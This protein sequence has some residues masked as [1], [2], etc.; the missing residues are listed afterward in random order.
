MILLSK[1][2]KLFIRSS[3]ESDTPIRLDGRNLMEERMIEIELSR[4]DHGSICE[5]N[6]GNTRVICVTKWDIV[7]PFHDRPN[8]GMLN[9]L[10]KLSHGTEIAHDN[11][12]NSGNSNSN[13]NNNIENESEFI[14]MLERSIKESNTLD[15]E[16]LCIVSNEKV[17]SIT[18]TINIIN[19]NGNC[20]DTAVLATMGGLRVFRKPEISL[21][22]RKININ[23]INNDN[24]NK[25]SSSSSS[26]ND[27]EMIMDLKI[28]SSDE[29]EPLPLAIHHTPLCVTMYC[30][31]ISSSSSSS[32]LSSSSKSNSSN[33]IIILLDATHE[34]EVLC[35]TKITFTFN[36]HDELCSIFKRGGEGLSVCDVMTCHT[37]SSI[38]VKKLHSLLE[39]CLKAYEIKHE[40]LKKKRLKALRNQVHVSVSAGTSDVDI[41]SDN[42]NININSSSSSDINPK[43]LDYSH[44]HEAAQLPP[45]PP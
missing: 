10:I 3:I 13:S 15:T 1:N 32:S 8:D 4:N 43:I 36:G 27:D 25:K 42:N 12:N 44:L 26:S 6:Y 45:S 17:W 7:E 29:K 11:H 38:I 21:I 28:Y 16:S 2:D 41:E 9:F 19:Y 40:E 18:C 31:K 33:D 35:D 34:E 14:R 39:E 23:N 37:Q 22:S 20:I 24:N 5:V 30:Y